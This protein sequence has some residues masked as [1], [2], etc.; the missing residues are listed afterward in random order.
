M[1]RLI[2]TWRRNADDLYGQRLDGNMG[3]NGAKQ[4]PRPSFFGRSKLSN[5]KLA[6]APERSSPDH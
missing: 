2:M 3:L 6:I 5:G 4:H 1:F